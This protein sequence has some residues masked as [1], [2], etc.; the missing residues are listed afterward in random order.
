MRVLF[1]IG[2]TFVLAISLIP[3]SAFSSRRV[4][5]GGNVVVC[6]K[7]GTSVENA[8]PSKLSISTLDIYEARGLNKSYQLDLGKPD[9]SVDA[10]IEI[11]LRRLDG[12]SGARAAFYRQV[13]QSFKTQ[14]LTQ[15]E[16][17]PTIADYGKLAVDLPANC[18]IK[19]MAI[20]FFSPFQMNVRKILVNGHYRPY[21]SNDEMAALYIHELVTSEAAEWGATSSASFRPF[22]A[23]LASTK[24]ASI[25]DEAF[26]RETLAAGLMSYECHGFT[27][28]YD[29]SLSGHQEPIFQN[30]TLI[31]GTIFPG[32]LLHARS[33]L[34]TENMFGIRDRMKFYPS[35][36]VHEVILSKPEM[37]NFDNAK[38]FPAQSGDRVVFA[39]DGSVD[40]IY[41]VDH[42][43]D[44]TQK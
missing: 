15:D 30:G 20:Q 31:E 19:Q 33:R 27:F 13:Y 42:P 21:I 38:P 25:S 41:M 24:L 9:L 16:D 6:T 11:F 40:A 44:G 37:I 2:T 3:S 10:K 17:F 22:V 34:G 32:T 8:D 5:N 4:G 14:G 43:G 35:G 26:I 23:F 7:D 12:I 1:S 39:E 18:A 36:A 28:L 29:P